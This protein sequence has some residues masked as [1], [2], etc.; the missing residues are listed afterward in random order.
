MIFGGRGKKRDENSTD[1]PSQ[2]AAHSQWANSSEQLREVVEVIDAARD[3][4]GDEEMEKA[5]GIVDEEISSDSDSS[6]EHE[7]VPDGSPEHKQG[8]IDQ[9]RD[10]KRRDKALHRQ[11]RGLMQWKVR[12][13][14]QQM[15]KRHA[16]LDK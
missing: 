10:Y 5:A 1:M 9:V 13:F 6:D 14:S 15:N 16:S 3:A 11:H 2:G 4:L 12:H 8:P 7:Y